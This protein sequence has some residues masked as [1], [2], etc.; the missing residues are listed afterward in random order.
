MSDSQ[1]TTSHKQPDHPRLIQKVTP[2]LFF[3]PPAD[4]R[5]LTDAELFAFGAALKARM[6]E[7]KHEVVLHD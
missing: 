2:V 5:A 6:D 7:R 3:C 4:L 1:S